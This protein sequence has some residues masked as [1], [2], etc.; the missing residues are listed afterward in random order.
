VSDES[1]IRPGVTLW[2]TGLPAAG[3]TTVAYATERKLADLGY[4]AMVLDGD[5]LRRGLSRDLGL[6]PEDRSEQARRAAHVA[7]L[8]ARAGLVAIVSLVSPYLK[9]RQRAREIHQ[10][11]GLIFN[12]IWIDTPL[13]VCEQRD[14]KGLYRRARAGELRGLTG[15][16]AP[17]EPPL[18]AELRIRTH[19]ESPDAAAEQV[20]CL[21]EAVAVR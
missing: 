12:E 21:I 19:E 16:D 9:D 20:A 14:P 11:E 7:V 13:H 8:L 17:Y 6:S 5:V 2:L 10:A 1:P 18:N 4:V 3:K 15:I